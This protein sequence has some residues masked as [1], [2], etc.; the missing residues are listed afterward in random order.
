MLLHG[1]LDQRSNVIT[2]QLGPQVFGIT[3]HRLK[4]QTQ[5]ICDFLH[6][7]T[8]R[9]QSKYFTFSKGKCWGNLQTLVESIPHLLT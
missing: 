3:V 6:R 7:I 1:S 4:A 9:K 8:L 2:A 5:S